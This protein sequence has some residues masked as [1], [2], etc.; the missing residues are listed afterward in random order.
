MRHLERYV[1]EEHVEDFKDGLITRRELIRRVTL[2]TGSLAMSMSV[3]AALGCDVSRPAE[4]PAA[5]TPTAPQ[6][7]SLTPLPAVAY[8]TPPAAPTSDGVTVRG[9]DPRI[10]AQAVSVKA[11]DGASLIGYLARPKA[12]GRYAGVLVVHE[13]RGLLEHIR[14]VVRRVATA[15]FVG[16]STSCRARAALTS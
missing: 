11:Q 6:P 16:R 14:D 3:L 2:I 10:A 8:A 5:R 7:A 9:D 1:L 4:S 15:G 13:N 12:E